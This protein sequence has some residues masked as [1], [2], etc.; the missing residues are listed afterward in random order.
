MKITLY[1][2]KVN[3]TYYVAHITIW[4]N[5]EIAAG[6]FV[7]CMLTAPKLWQGNGDKIRNLFSKIFPCFRSNPPFARH[8]NSI[9]CPLPPVKDIGIWTLQLERVDSLDSD[10]YDQDRWTSRKVLITELP[11]RIE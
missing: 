10:K 9:F 11:T 5:A 1:G 7:A 4:S 3:V 6:V 2:T 8:A